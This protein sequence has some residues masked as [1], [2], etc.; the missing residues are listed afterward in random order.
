MA[1]LLTFQ[2]A[3][4]RFNATVILCSTPTN[5]VTVA[6][7]VLTILF[8]CYIPFTIMLVFDVIVFKRLRKSKRRV[9]VIQMG[10]RKQSHQISNKEYNFI[11]STI[12]IDLTFVLFYTPTAAHSSITVA[13][14]Y[15]NWDRITSAAISVFNS[16]SLFLAFLYSVV[17]FFIFFILNRYF[18]NEVFTILRI[19]KLFPDL[20][21]TMM[22]TGSIINRAAH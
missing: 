1:N 18:R 21:Q 8:R 5:E 9:G 2:Q 17:Q 20:N 13:D 19:N 15:I 6:S 14:V 4:I 22:E 12:I 16:C 10:Q 3:A 11:I 7:N